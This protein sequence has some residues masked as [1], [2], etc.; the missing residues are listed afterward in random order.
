MP[1]IN[2]GLPAEALERN[3]FRGRHSE[4]SWEQSARW[5]CCQQGPR[6]E[7]LP[8]SRLAGN[9]LKLPQWVL[10]GGTAWTEKDLEDTHIRTLQ[11]QRG[12]VVLGLGEE[13][14]KTVPQRPRVQWGLRTGW[15]RSEAAGWHRV[16][17]L[18]EC[19]HALCGDSW[20]LNL[21]LLA[22]GQ[23]LPTG[24]ATLPHDHTDPWTA[25]LLDIDRLAGAAQSQA[26]DDDKQL[27]EQRESGV[28][29]KLSSN[30]SCWPSGGY[31]SGFCSHLYVKPINTAH[32]LPSH[33]M[34]PLPP[35][36]CTKLVAT[37]LGGC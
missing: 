14:A 37:K 9:A 12:R 6:E 27:P 17:E 28:T 4:R 30:M 13:L 11:G 36:G 24:Q 34:L 18:G 8:G 22:P 21:G 25:L 19:H 2:T 10:S 7:R 31:S 26:Q 23:G 33:L 15:G 20:D 1:F 35:H 3:A 5:H 16:G 32:L 29:W